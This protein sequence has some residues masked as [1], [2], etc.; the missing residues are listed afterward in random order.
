MDQKVAKFAQLETHHK[1]QCHAKK[2]LKARV[3]HFFK[4]LCV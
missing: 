2:Y 4:E 3:C 1:E